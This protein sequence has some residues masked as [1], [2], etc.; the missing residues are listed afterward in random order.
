MPQTAAS[1]DYYRP[2][3]LIFPH[4]EQD[5]FALEIKN[6]KLWITLWVNL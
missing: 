2:Q 1:D 5:G 4:S 3:P 6:N